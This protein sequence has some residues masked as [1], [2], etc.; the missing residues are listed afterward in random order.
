MKRLMIFIDNSNIFHGSRRE[1]IKFDYQKI[2]NFLAESAIE[3]YDLT[4]V[5]MYCAVDRSQPESRRGC[6][7]EERVIDSSA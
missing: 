6:K 7:R 3:R 4:R 5:I 2:V 1:N